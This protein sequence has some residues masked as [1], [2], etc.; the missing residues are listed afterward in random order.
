MHEAK[1]KKNFRCLFKRLHSL[2]FCRNFGCIIFIWFL[3]VEVFIYQLIFIVF[4]LFLPE[5]DTAIPMDRLL[6]KVY[7][8]VHH[9]FH[10]CQLL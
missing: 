4:T 2:R 5:E 1:N 6:K 7:P 3:C 8:S 9:F 10:L